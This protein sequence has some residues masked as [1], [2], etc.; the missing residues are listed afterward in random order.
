V[1]VI[2]EPTAFAQ[3]RETSLRERR[4]AVDIGS[5]D[6][7]CSAAEQMLTIKEGLGHYYA[8]SGLSSGA[9]SV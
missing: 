7:D 6:A 8:G 1:G 9:I 2:L 3:Q 4:A 5:P